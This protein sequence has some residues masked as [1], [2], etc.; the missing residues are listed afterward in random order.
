MLGGFIGIISVTLFPTFIPFILTER[1]SHS[2]FTSSSFFVLYTVTLKQGWRA[3]WID[4]NF[5][6]KFMEILKLKFDYSV[7]PTAQKIIPQCKINFI[8]SF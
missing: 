8:I 5:L 7:E 3:V 4:C 2:G 1:D 6:C